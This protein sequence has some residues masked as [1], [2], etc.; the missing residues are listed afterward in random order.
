MRREGEGTFLVRESLFVYENG[1]K[2]RAYGLIV[3]FDFSPFFDC[4]RSIEIRKEI[5]SRHYCT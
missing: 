4:S 2:S 1:I 3:S 5:I